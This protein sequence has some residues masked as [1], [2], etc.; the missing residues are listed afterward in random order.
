MPGS[1]EA[2]Q[3]YVKIVDAMNQLFGVHAGYRPVHAKGIV[4]EGTFSP[5]PSAA[6]LSRAP[7]LQRDSVKATIRFSD[8][9]GVPQIPDTDPNASPR[10]M[11]IKFHL[12]GGAITDIVAHSLNGFPVPNAEEFLGFITALIASG[13]DAPKPSQIEQ[14][15][16]THPRA[17]R[18]A[19]APKPTPASFAT[20]SY[21]GVDA[22]RLINAAGSVRCARY[23]I[24][25]AAGE[26]YLTSTEAATRSP[27]FL[28]EELAKRLAKGPAS[29]QV[30]AQ[31]AEPGDSTADPSQTW[32]DSR[33]QV[34]LGT[35]SIE[36][37]RADSD[38]VQRKM[39]FDPVNLT[40]GIELGDDD[41]PAARSAIYSV[42]Y[43][44]RN[45]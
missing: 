36:A 45:P 30:V 38:M 6:S 14:F 15:L 35:L 25:P 32:P 42:S 12:P 5:A 11:A 9:A 4:C 2:Q 31:L 28:A 34:V 22:F 17:M 10:G 19:T 20:E 29:F 27:D 40:D 37:L 43:K 23:Q 7:H 13:P 16:A 8:F 41:L 18:F 26:Q 3:T 44:R 21:Y 33:P 39:I 24:R 1:N